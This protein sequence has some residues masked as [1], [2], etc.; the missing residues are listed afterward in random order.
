MPNVEQYATSGELS[1]A[2][3]AHIARRKQRAS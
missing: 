3:D 1:D 2:M